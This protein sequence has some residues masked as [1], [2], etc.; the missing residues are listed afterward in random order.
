VLARAAARRPSP[1]SAAAAPILTAL[2]KEMVDQ[3]A[4]PGAAWIGR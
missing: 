3:Q 4:W 2:M 1:A